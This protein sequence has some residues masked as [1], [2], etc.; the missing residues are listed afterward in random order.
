MEIVN[1]FIIISYVRINLYIRIWKTRQVCSFCIGLIRRSSKQRHCLDSLFD[2]ISLFQ[3][4]ES[5]HF[6][7]FVHI[8]PLIDRFALMLVM[9]KTST[10]VF[11]T[12]STMLSAMITVSSAYRILL[13]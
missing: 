13:Y 12:R 2:V 10:L 1:S 5:D 8:L 3:T 4:I 9:E 6:K 7:E 11:R